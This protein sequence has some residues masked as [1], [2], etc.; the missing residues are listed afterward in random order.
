MVSVATW[1][2]SMTMFETSGPL[3]SVLRPR[4]LSPAWPADLN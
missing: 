4:V 1:L 2:V 3:R